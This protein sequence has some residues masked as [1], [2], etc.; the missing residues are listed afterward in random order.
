MSQSH[1]ICCSKEDTCDAAAI[2]AAIWLSLQ[3]LAISFFRIC[4]AFVGDTL[5]N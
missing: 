3:Q 5:V 2:G 1:V 4:L